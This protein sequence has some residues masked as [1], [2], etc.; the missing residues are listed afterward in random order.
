MGGRKTT[1]GGA[2]RT[3][4]FIVSV[5]ETVTV[6][7]TREVSWFTLNFDSQTVYYFLGADTHLKDSNM[8]KEMVSLFLIFFPWCP[9]NYRLFRANMTPWTDKIRECYNSFTRLWPYS[10]LYV[11]TLTLLLILTAVHILI[12]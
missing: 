12:R 11:Y 3:L 9:T 10:E 6:F 4:G 1:L 2:V 5:V 7:F 8:N